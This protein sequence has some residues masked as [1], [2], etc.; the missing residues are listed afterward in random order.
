MRLRGAVESPLLPDVRIGTSG[1]VYP[2]WMTRFY[3]ADLPARAWLPFYADHFDTLE[4]NSPFYR[5][6]DARVF[7]RWRQAVPPGFTFAVKASRYLTHMRKLLH[8]AEP[9]HRLLT[10]ARRLDDTLGPVL[11]QLPG[12]FAANLPR[13][14]RFLLVLGRQRHVARL[15]AVLEVRHPSWLE[16]AVLD[17]LRAANVALCLADWRECPVHDVVTAD[18]VYVRRHGSGRRYGGSYPERA[19]QA[20]ARVIEG[21]R[22]R[23][24]DVYVYFN[25]DGAGAAVRNAR[26]LREIV[27]ASSVHVP[28]RAVVGARA[29]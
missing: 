7:A 11:F 21:W 15:R 2:H 3:P 5:L 4:L 14:D 13:L 8:P 24:L 19:L 6:P 26:R 17:R 27:T 25:N 22:R 16:P 9:L 29:S 20:D 1:Y 18:F 23:G 12:R 28:P 10:R